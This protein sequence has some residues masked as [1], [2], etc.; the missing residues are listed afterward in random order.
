MDEETTTSAPV[1][2]GDTIQGVQIDDQGQAVS[3]PETTDS[4]EA[5]QEPSP[6]AKPQ[7]PSTD[8]TSDWLK[9]K[10]IDPS[11]PEAITKLAKSAREAERAMHAKAQKASELEKTIESQSDEY[12]EQTALQTG[13]DPELLKRVQRVEVQSAVRDFFTENPEAR[14][15]ET[16]M[17]AELQ[18]RPYLAGDLDALYKVV[19]A[20]D[21][22]SVKSQASKDTLTKLAQN[23]QAAVPT[24]NAVNSSNMGEPA[25]SAANVD[26]LVATHDQKWFE[27][28]YDAINKAM[29]Q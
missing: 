16:E 20:S 6:E 27:A 7:E 10:G 22:D 9:K 19:K 28:N 11:D 5:V 21:L 3:Q 26:Q 29:A 12:A 17:I 4:A 14:E 1:A 8:D 18:K 13:Q 15:I 24:G 25:I 23:Q 2:T